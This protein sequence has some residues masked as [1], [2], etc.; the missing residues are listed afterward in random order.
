MSCQDNIDEE[1]IK[2]RHII[3][4]ISLPGTSLQMIPLMFSKALIGLTYNVLRAIGVER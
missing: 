2:L 1:C 3:T 4:A